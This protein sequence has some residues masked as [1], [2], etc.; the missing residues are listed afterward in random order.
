VAKCEDCGDYTEIPRFGQYRCETCHKPLMIDANKPMPVDIE[1]N[2]NRE[3][4]CGHRRGSHAWHN[5]APTTCMFTKCKC[6]VYAVDNLEW[7]E[8]NRGKKK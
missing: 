2:Y 4:A 3:C 6:K 5:D 1:I 8:K 7:L